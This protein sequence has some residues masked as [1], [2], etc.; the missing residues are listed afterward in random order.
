MRPP[1]P[2]KPSQAHKTENADPVEQH[3]PVPKV[4]LA[5][6]CGLL[7]WAVSYIVIE[8][9]DGTAALGDRRDA[10]ALAAPAGQGTVADGKQL[11]AANCQACHQA[12]GQG[13]PGVFPPLAASPWVNG[14]PDRLAQILLHGMTGPLDVL[15]TTYNGAM[16]AFGEQFSDAE[17]AALATH[18]RSQWGNHAA[19]VDAAQIA[20]ARTA[21]AAQKEPWHG[22]EALQ[23]FIGGAGSAK[24]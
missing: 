15:G 21:S 3:N 16:P 10:A 20:A 24:P 7:V 6:V 17:I 22:G 19:P 1:D 2:M 9:A 18:I 23:A 4:V 8:R 14:E 5:L 12:G 11:F 13:I